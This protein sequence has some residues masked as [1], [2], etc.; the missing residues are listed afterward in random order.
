LRSSATE[1]H[2]AIIIGADGS[3]V[4]PE[5]ELVRAQVE[6]EIGQAMEDRLRSIR[7]QVG[8]RRMLWIMVVI[9]QGEAVNDPTQAIANELAYCATRLDGKACKGWVRE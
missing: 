9:A 8:W 7:D 1:A 3:E 2:M 6:L 5:E 4:I